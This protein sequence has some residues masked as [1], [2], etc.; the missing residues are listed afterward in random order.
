MSVDNPFE[1]SSGSY[2]DRSGKDRDVV[3][4]EVSTRTIEL[5]NQTRPW[6]QAIG[7]LMWIGTVFLGIGAVF[8]VAASLMTQNTE[9]ALF[10]ILYVAMTLVYGALARSL[11]T[12]ASRINTLN[13]SEQ[14]R[15][16]EDAL[17][18]QKA[19]WRL[20]GIIMLVA[21]VVYVVILGLMISGV[22]MIGT[23]P[24]H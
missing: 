21:I 24:R 10:S 14:V 18:A 11:T 8:T 7:V 16:L 6:V 1:V 23:L 9:F 4:A 12:Y 17:A 22:L 15:D 19:F 5:L 13:A 2:G 20:A 3:A